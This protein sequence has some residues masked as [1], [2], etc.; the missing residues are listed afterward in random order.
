MKNADVQKRKLDSRKIIGGIAVLGIIGIVVGTCVRYWKSGQQT[1]RRTS[2]EDGSASSAVAA[3]VKLHV[4]EAEE[5]PKITLIS[6]PPQTEEI[7]EIFPT[8]SPKNVVVLT[9]GKKLSV[10]VGNP[11][12]GVEFYKSS[13]RS[14]HKDELYERVNSIHLS[15]FK[16]LYQE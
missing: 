9:N 8:N 6:F 13:N 3:E 14:T 2:S 15:H 1:E 11:R 7:T 10:V 5:S 16:D 12:E 4:S